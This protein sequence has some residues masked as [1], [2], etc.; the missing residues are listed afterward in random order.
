MSSR[1]TRATLPLGARIV[2]LF[3]DGA[4][5]YLSKFPIAELDI[6]D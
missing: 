1:G 2:T 5:R 4:E 3:P 6:R